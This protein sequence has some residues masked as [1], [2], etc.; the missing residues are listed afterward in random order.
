[1]TLSYSTILPQFKKLIK[2]AQLRT[3]FNDI[4]NRFDSLNPDNLNF[5]TK[6]GN[7]GRVVRLN[8]GA[9]A[10]EYKKAA[11]LDG[12]TL[13]NKDL[14][15]YDSGSGDF[16]RLAIG[17]N[18]TALQVSGGAY[19][20]GALPAGALTVT[21]IQTTGFTA[22]DGVLYPC[23][24]TSAGFTATLPLTPTA[25][26]RVAIVDIAGTASSNNI[27]VGR[28]GSEIM[29]LA[30]DLIIDI[31]YA[32]VYLVYNATEGWLIL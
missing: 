29:G 20:F 12:T 17:A 28:N 31:D 19:T 10:L 18:G 15:F 21:S 16:T 13:V 3:L 30:E 5:P 9:T 4:K 32:K 23:D 2:S 26:M 6:A 22:T 25:G 8:A 1:M 14:I 7:G 11:T 24:T 27:T